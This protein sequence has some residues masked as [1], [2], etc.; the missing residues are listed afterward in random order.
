ME[1]SRKWFGLEQIIGKLW[2]REV[3]LCYGRIPDLRIT[4]IDHLL[5]HQIFWF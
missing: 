3:A 2:E 5:T 1:I 4:A